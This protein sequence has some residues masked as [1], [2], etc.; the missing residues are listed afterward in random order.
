MG[1]D[2]PTPPIA[3]GPDETT[4]RAEFDKW[5][6]ENIGKIVSSDDDSPPKTSRPS[7]IDPPPASSGLTL[8][9][10]EDWMKTREQSSKEASDRTA[11]S[12][13]VQ[14]LTDRMDA[15]DKAERRKSWFGLPW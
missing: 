6:N 4:R 5:F 15:R 3:T 8:K 14:Q 10:V 2:K 1:E 13:A 11:L 12:Q 7:K 9:D